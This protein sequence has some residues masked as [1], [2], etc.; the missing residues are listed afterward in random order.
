MRGPPPNHLPHL[1]DCD[2]T[3]NP[4]ETA[5]RLAT[6]NDPEIVYSYC[7]TLYNVPQAQPASA[8]G[9]FSTSPQGGGP[10]GARAADSAARTPDAKMEVT[11]FNAVAGG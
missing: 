3:G 5:D 1:R 9:R 6:R 8:E 11:S 4:R 2:P 7:D 10:A